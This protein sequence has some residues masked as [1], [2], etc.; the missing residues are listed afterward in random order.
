MSRFIYLR[1]A[2][3]KVAFALPLMPASFSSDNICVFLLYAREIFLET[4]FN[5]PVMAIGNIYKWLLCIFHKQSKVYTPSQL[6]R[7]LLY[8]IYFVWKFFIN[9]LKT[10]GGI[11]AILP[12]KIF[13]VSFQNKDEISS[14]VAVKVSYKILMKCEII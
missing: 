14:R 10:V 8:S 3:Y 11:G 1:Q 2:F 9:F 5:F 13:N 7:I 4:V 6:C 12:L